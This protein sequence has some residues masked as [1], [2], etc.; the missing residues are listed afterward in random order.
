[1]PHSLGSGIFRGSFGGLRVAPENGY[2]GG[3]EII[4]SFLDEEAVDAFTFTVVPTFSCIYEVQHRNHSSTGSSAGVRH[5][6]QAWTESHEPN[7]VAPGAR[8]LDR[9]DLQGCVAEQMRMRKPPVG[10]GLEN[11]SQNGLRAW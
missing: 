3:G 10:F 4:A 6:S 1:M 2:C 11:G 8:P 9:R 5:D 7:Y